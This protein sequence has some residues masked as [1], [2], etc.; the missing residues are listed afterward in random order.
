MYDALL[1]DVYRYMFSRR[2]KI[3]LNVRLLYI[4]MRLLPWITS[5]IFK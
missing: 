5:Q 4:Y 3:L 2:L 1:S